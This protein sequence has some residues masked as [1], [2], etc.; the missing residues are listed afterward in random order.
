MPVQGEWQRQFKR[1]NEQ[2]AKIRDE[3]VKVELNS[4]SV[5]SEG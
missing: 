1:E 4:L 3:L 2:T 5:W